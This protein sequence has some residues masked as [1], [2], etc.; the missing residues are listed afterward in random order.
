MITHSANLGDIFVPAHA[1]WSKQS[2]YTSLAKNCF[3]FAQL[4][5]QQAHTELVDYV[6]CACFSLHIA[7]F[8]S[9]SCTYLHVFILA[10]ALA[11]NVCHTHGFIYLITLCI[12]CSQPS[13]RTRLC[14]MP[15]SKTWISVLSERPHQSSYH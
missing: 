3:S 8:V 2:M 10:C 1:N 12:I 13:S 15:G 4:T 11:Y 7:S 5:Y 9:C 6:E 14:G